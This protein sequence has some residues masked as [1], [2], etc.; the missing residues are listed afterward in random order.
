[1]FQTTLLLAGFLL[2]YFVKPEACFVP[3][4]AFFDISSGQDSAV[5][6]GCS[7]SRRPSR[8]VQSNPSLE[9]RSLDSFT[10]WQR[11]RYEWIW[12]TT[13]TSGTSAGVY[14]TSGSVSLTPRRFLYRHLFDCA[15][16]RYNC[17]YSM[18]RA[19]ATSYLDRQLYIDE[20]LYE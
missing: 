1:M 13:L 14:T 15:N 3:S 12:F 20:Q 19:N 16:V 5:C 7:S 17:H 10:I 2:E 11:N 6:S 4:I 18:S 8:S 9:K